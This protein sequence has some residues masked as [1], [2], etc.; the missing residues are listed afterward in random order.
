MKLLDE[1]GLETVWS[2]CKTKFALS[3]HTHNYAG[4]GSPGGSANSAIGVVDY[5]QTSKTIQIGYSGTGISGDQIKYIAG[6]TDGD[7]NVNAKI[8]DVSKDALKKWLGIDS[9]DNNNIPTKLSQLINDKGFVT[10]SVSGNTITINGVSTTWANTWRGIQNNLTSSSTSDSLSA[11]QGR[12]LKGLI[13]GKAN[14]SHTHNWSQISGV[15]VATTAQSG[16]MSAA[17]KAKLDEIALHVPT[18]SQ[19]PT[20]STI[21]F[22]E[23]GT[24]KQFKI[25]DICR[26]ADSSSKYG[27]K[28]Y[29]LYNIASNRATWGEN[30]G[31][32]GDYNETVTVTLTSTVS[33]SDS[34]LNGVVV[35]VKNTMTNETQTQTW[36]GTPLVFKIPSV[37]TYTVSAS[38]VFGYGTPVKLSYTAGV[39]TS[40][41]VV[42][43]YKYIPIGI[44]IYDTDGNFTKADDWKTANNGK[45]VGVSVRTEN[46]SFVI[47]PTYDS[48]TKSWCKYN[49]TIS[50]IVTSTDSVT[51]KKDYAGELNTDKIIAQLGIGNAPAAEYCRSLTFKNGKKGYLWSL[52]E[53]YDAYSNKES[54]N[55]AMSKIGGTEIQDD[56]EYWTSTQYS[57][58]YAWTLLSGSVRGVSSKYKNN[59][60]SVC[61]VCAF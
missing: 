48:E 42:I 60:N 21:T 35:T 61:V 29:Q 4:S 58:N 54:I 31:A 34:K 50:G 19:A 56:Y 9:L 40:R 8:K 24:T 47:A 16:I 15:P 20:S 51:A 45:A 2:T 57:D 44:Y 28:F 39:S 53:A 38:S 46:S 52:G 37:N 17:D 14:S 25:G 55:A 27:Y 32:G 12:I 41:A 13:D 23:N 30:G 7:G 3:G 11:N 33:S 49:T 1:K 22:V 5:G 43:S 26:V 59:T 18:L 36:N 6:Y 10:G